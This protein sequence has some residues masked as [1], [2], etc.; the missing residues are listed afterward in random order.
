MKSLFFVSR[1]R[2]YRYFLSAFSSASCQHFSTVY[3]SHSLSKTVFVS[4]FSFRWLK[5]SFAHDYKSLSSVKIVFCF[6]FMRITLKY[7]AFIGLQTFLSMPQYLEVRRRV[8]IYKPFSVCQTELLN[9]FYLFLLP[10]RA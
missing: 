10:L 1:F 6:I 4:S 3:S 8:Q 9:N 2:R 7:Q 5:C